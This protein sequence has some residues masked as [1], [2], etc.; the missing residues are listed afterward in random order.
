MPCGKCA[1]FTQRRISDARPKW[2]PNV[3]FSSVRILES[4]DNHPPITLAVSCLLYTLKKPHN[5][6]TVPLFALYFANCTCGSLHGA[7]VRYTR[8]FEKKTAG[9]L[10][11]FFYSI[12]SIS[13][14]FCG[15]SDEERMSCRE[16]QII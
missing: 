13:Q 5:V 16:H 3:F 15:K 9:K 8:S 11:L 10:N 14:R 12:I 4:S 1:L 6:K 2:I 7:H